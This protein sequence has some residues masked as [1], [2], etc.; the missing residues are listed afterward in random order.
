[1]LKFGTKQVLVMVKQVAFGIYLAESVKNTDERVLLPKKQVPDEMEIGDPIE[2]FLYKDSEDRPIAT[3]NEPK[4]TLGQVARLKVSAVSRIGA[5]LE[6][7]LEKDLFLPFREQTAP[8]KE[9]DEALVSLYLDKSERLCATMKLYPFLQ[10]DSPYV[11][12][13]EVTGTVYEI[14]DNFGA[15]V[16]VDDKYSALIPRKEYVKDIAV[17]ARITARVA[18]VK[19]DGK[20]DLSV[21]QKAHLQ[22][23]EDAQRLL[24][25]LAENGGRLSIHDKSSPQEIRAVTAM[26]KNEFKR[27]VGRL[28]KE[29]K[30]ALGQDGISLK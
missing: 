13:D 9:G 7:G 17:A 26:S 19:E 11:K 28:Y 24:A 2:V 23:D 8:V 25:L 10:T 15:F 5:F 18:Q 29:H 12:D 6:W 4:L 16:A 14:S 1:M 22:M 27:A 3:V 30:I 21:R 20:L